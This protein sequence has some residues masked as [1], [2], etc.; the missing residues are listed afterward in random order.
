MNVT[1]F[2]RG[3]N[4]GSRCFESCESS[5]DSSLQM[6]RTHTAA[7]HAFCPDVTLLYLLLYKR[8]PPKLHHAR[9]L[10]AHQCSNRIHAYGVDTAKLRGS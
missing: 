8:H 7:Y 6:C 9:C 10:C 5:T 3:Q 2:M 4:L 1:R